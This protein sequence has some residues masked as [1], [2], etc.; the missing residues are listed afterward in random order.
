MKKRTWIPLAIIVF[1]AAAV[2]GPYLL[3]K[4][5]AAEQVPAR[6]RHPP[7]PQTSASKEVD[8]TL[9]QRKLEGIGNTRDLK[10]NPIQH[11]AGR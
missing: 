1:V 5:Q 8:D 3:V 11:G 10:P 4:Y 7:I 2:G 6:A 9:T